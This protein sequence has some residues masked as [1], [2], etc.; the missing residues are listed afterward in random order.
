MSILYANVAE[1]H[2]EYGKHDTPFTM[3]DSI[4]R[5]ASINHVE[6]IEREISTGIGRVESVA[7]ISSFDR[8]QN[9]T[10][11]VRLFTKRMI[12]RVSGVM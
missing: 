5:S 12:G 11:G 10:L 9:I 1:S 3:F 2:S 6:R 8:L 4:Q 7:Q